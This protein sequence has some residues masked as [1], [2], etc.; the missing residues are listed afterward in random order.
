MVMGA[1]KSLEWVKS[2]NDVEVFI[3]IRTDA[4]YEE[5]FSPGFKKYLSK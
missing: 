5:M 4:G 1:E 3:I 2:K